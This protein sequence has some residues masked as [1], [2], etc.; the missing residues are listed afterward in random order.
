MPLG[1]EKQYDYISKTL[2]P[3]ILAKYPA[4]YKSIKGLLAK[5]I[6]ETKSITIDAVGQVTAQMD[7]LLNNYGLQCGGQQILGK[8]NILQTTSNKMD[9]IKKMATGS[10]FDNIIKDYESLLLGDVFVVS[11]GHNEV[12]RYTANGQFRPKGSF[13][14]G[15][16]GDGQ[17]I[18]PKG[19]K[20]RHTTDSLYVVDSGNNRVQVFTSQGD[21]ITKW[22]HAGVG[23]VQFHAPYDIAFNAAQ[24]YAYVTDTGNNRVQI[25]LASSGVYIGEWGSTGTGAGEFNGPRGIAVDSN[26]FVYVADSGN[27]RIQKFDQVGLYKAYWSVPDNPVGI[28]ILGNKVYVTCASS[29]L[30]KVFT[31]NGVFIESYAGGL[32]GP[33]G[34]AIGAVRDVAIFIT[35]SADSLHE[36]REEDRFAVQEIGL[37]PEGI[38]LGSGVNNCTDMVDIVKNINSDIATLDLSPINTVFG[39]LTDLLGRAA[40]VLATIATVLGCGQEMLAEASKIIPAAGALNSTVSKAIDNVD[41]AQDKVSKSKIEIKY[42]SNLSPY[43]IQLDNANV[44]QDKITVVIDGK[45]LGNDTVNHPTNPDPGK[46]SLDYIKGLVYF[47][48]KQK[49]RQANIT[50]SYADLNDIFSDA[51]DTTVKDLGLDVDLNRHKATLIALNKF[52]K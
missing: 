23:P 21:F 44:L 39:E 13:G 28:D 36:F 27:N 38:T 34:I 42:V 48:A 15:G 46:F 25:I 9:L 17:F 45:T 50:Y 24:T 2:I 22:G 12:I 1:I 8:G 29:N 47:N 11:R 26:G 14:S 20:Y 51:K 52:F 7:D 5:A 4:C 49:S 41:K 40:T 35:D 37:E 43:I 33:K 6:E 18:T 10:I 30:V 32:D 3:G 16:S 19:I 31:T